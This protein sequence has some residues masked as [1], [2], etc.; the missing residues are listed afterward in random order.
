MPGG[1][2]GD[3]GGDDGG[4]R[5]KGNREEES[6]LGS[7]KHLVLREGGFVVGK[8]GGVVG[9]RVCRRAKVQ[10]KVRLARAKVKGRERRAKE[11]SGVKSS[12]G[13]KRG[14]RRREGG[15]FCRRRGPCWTRLGSRPRTG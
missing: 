6:G 7:G 15:A 9:K 11:G 3:G 4:D 12:G 5:R 1:E 14:E 13:L 2:D 10:R 8:E